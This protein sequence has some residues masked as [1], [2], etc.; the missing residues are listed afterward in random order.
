MNNPWVNLP[1]L[2]PYILPSDNDFVE[3]H[4]NKVSEN[5]QIQTNLYPE[6]FLGNPNSN[7]ILLNLN[8]GFTPAEFYYHTDDKYFV[9]QIQANLCHRAKYPFFLLDPL[10]SESPGGKWWNKR[11]K[12]IILQTSLDIVSNKIFCIELF[13]YHS[14]NFRMTGSSI[15]SQEYSFEILKLAIQREA[16]IILMRGR[17]SWEKSFPQLK[18]CNYYSL[19]NPRS[20][21][22][23][24]NN[25]P[26]GV[27]EKIIERLKQ[28]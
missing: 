21:Y 23:S 18:D 5:Y 13:P 14:K 27:F 3:H 7:I 12:Q 17:I 2:P 1:N 15:E 25:L 8:P 22:I 6:P 19:K 4:N 20:P 10:V 9:E 11:L 16:L 28:C 24:K 26:D